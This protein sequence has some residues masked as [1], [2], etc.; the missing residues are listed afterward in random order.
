MADHTEYVDRLVHG[1]PFTEGEEMKYE[2]VRLASMNKLSLTSYARLNSLAVSGIY[3][4]ER[5]R[6]LVCF[7]C[8]GKWP[9]EMISS[10]ILYSHG[11]SECSTVSREASN[12]STC[13]ASSSVRENLDTASGVCKVSS[14]YG[15][16]TDSNSGSDPGYD[17]ESVQGGGENRSRKPCIVTDGDCH[18]SHKQHEHCSSTGVS[19]KLRMLVGFSVSFGLQ[20]TC[21]TG[22]VASF[23]Q[24]HCYAL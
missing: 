10:E 1:P 24:S 5:S 2:L 14:S 11:G 17:S 23:S 19:I 4:N 8:L 16:D 3:Y 20:T 9:R 21:T 12:E 15:R 18:V 22:H 7:N 6:K 13:K